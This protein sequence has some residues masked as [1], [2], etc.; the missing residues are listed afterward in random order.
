MFPA[1][2]LLAALIAPE[3]APADVRVMSYN[4]RFA[5][6]GDGENV[7]ENRR[8][9]LADTIKA[10]GPDL[11]GTQEVLAR[12]R[13]DLAA[14]LD[15]YEVLAAGRDDG[16][17]K[18]EMMAL[19]F[20]KDRFEKLDSGH[21]WLS[22]TPDVPGSKGWD[23]SLPRMA[24][25]AKLRDRRAPDGPPIFFINTHFDHI[26][27]KSKAEAARLIR[28]R[29]DE[30]GRGSRVVL[31]G[32]FNSGVGSQAYWTLFATKLQRVHYLKD[33]YHTYRAAH[34][35]GGEAEGTLSGF[36]SAATKGPRIDW[37]GA[38]TDWTVREAGIVRADR[39]GRAPSD[40]HAVT[41]V[42]APKAD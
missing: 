19:F 6:P 18:G 13:D 12:Q 38:S 9:F 21:F 20:R 26:G 37:I 14:R 16:R 42:L 27:P 36:K 24:T 15:G 33:T 10:F 7:W 35:G 2:A 5:N 41:A 34:P 1:L 28:A 30:M 23:S 22:E 29:I 4:I 8:D 11:L 31:T 39:D 40:H 3:P 25:W 17:E 32:D